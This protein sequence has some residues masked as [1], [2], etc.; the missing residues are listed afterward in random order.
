[1]HDLQ[2]VVAEGGEMFGLPGGCLSENPVEIGSLTVKLV[3]GSM[4]TGNDGEEVG[5]M[6]HRRVNEN[7][8]GV[9]EEGKGI[10][11][12]KLLEVCTMAHDPAST[13][14]GIF[15]IADSTPSSP[16]TAEISLDNSHMG[17]IRQVETLVDTPINP[18]ESTVVAS[19]VR[20]PSVV[21]DNAVGTRTDNTSPASHQAVDSDTAHLAITNTTLA[22]SNARQGSQN[23]SFTDNAAANKIS[24]QT[25]YSQDQ[26]LSPSHLLGIQLDDTLTPS[27]ESID[28]TVPSLP[29]SSAI[30]SLKETPPRRSLPRLQ[31]NP[32]SPDLS[33]NYLIRSRDQFYT[34]QADIDTNARIPNNKSNIFPPNSSPQA[35]PTLKNASRSRSLKT[36]NAPSPALP[37][38]PSFNL[39]ILPSY[40]HTS[41]P[42][43]PLPPPS[44]PQDQPDSPL[45]P[46]SLLQRV[47]GGARQSSAVSQAQC[48]SIIAINTSTSSG[49]ESP[50]PHCA[51]T[52]PL[53]R[54]ASFPECP[55]NFL[56]PPIPTLPRHPSST[57]PHLKRT[58]SVNSKT[59]QDSKRSGRP[60][61]VIT[62]ISNKAY[63]QVVGRYVGVSVPTEEI[64]EYLKNN[65]VHP[66]FL[67]LRESESEKEFIQYYNIFTAR[68]THTIYLL[69]GISFIVYMLEFIQQPFTLH[70]KEFW[71]YLISALLM[72]ISYITGAHVL[73][74]AQV[75]GWQH[76]WVMGVVFL[77]VG[78]LSVVLTSQEASRVRQIHSRNFDTTETFSETLKTDNRSPFQSFVHG[79]RMLTIFTGITLLH[80]F[81]AAVM[82]GLSCAIGIWITVY[83][84]VPFIGLLGSFQVLASYGA[85]GIS[86][87]MMLRDRQWRRRRVFLLERLLAEKS[88]LTVLEICE[89]PT[90]DIARL[91]DTDSRSVQEDENWFED[92]ENL[93]LGMATE[94]QSLTSRLKRWVRKAVLAKWEDE[95]LEKMYMKWRQTLFRINLRRNLIILVLFDVSQLTFYSMSYCRASVNYSEQLC[96]SRGGDV[97]NLRIILT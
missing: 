51:L 43:P 56:T 67:N 95:E 44:F 33:F 45:Q 64:E 46:R 4:Q 93:N 77:T 78:V 34:S 41:P 61:S 38:S 26:I 94:R 54:P 63:E 81:S 73:N 13:S 50:P 7:E 71:F 8:G 42:L 58:P 49:E 90:E 48:P 19:A 79:S 20:V 91:K 28:D 9:V 16:S 24:I 31:R 47:L 96:G 25:G 5:M 57:S 37:K 32:G 10:N 65:G 86:A 21:V 6:E 36:R 17:V 27:S 15:V 75:A 53:P 40:Y 52:L 35:S 85:S 18:E 69:L 30:S 1:M 62:K 88:G 22:L 97:R 74:R 60:G 82:T 2:R 66:V 12:M 59:S 70:N 84:K 87:I 89:R 80:S 23:S 3:Q 72:F 83:I 76:F 92:G 14:T 68:S 29:R 11:E 39:N 55:Q